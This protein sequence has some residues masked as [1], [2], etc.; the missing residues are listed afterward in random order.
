MEREEKIAKIEKMLSA[1]IPTIE[2][3]VRRLEHESI[4]FCL[5]IGDKIVGVDIQ[6]SFMDSKTI[7]EIEAHFSERHI[8]HSILSNHDP[9][10]CDHDGVFT[11]INDPN[12]RDMLS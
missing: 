12:C 5:V 10:L 1:N 6:K 8:Y 2:K 3:I 7:Q 4:T 11:Y 9:K